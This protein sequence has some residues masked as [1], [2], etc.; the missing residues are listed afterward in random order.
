[1]VRAFSIFFLSFFLLHGLAQAQP[2]EFRDCATCPIMVNIPAG[3]FTMGTPAAEEEAEG[4]PMRAR[5]IAAPPTPIRI[6][7]GFAMSKHPVTLAEFT[8]FFQASQ[9]MP[10]NSCYVRVVEAGVMVTFAERR[11]RDWVLPGIEQLPSE[12]VVCVSWNDAQA[13]A[14][15]LSRQTGRTY[16]LASEAEWE[17]A[18]RAGTTG[19]RWWGGGRER[20]C[21]NA[22]VRDH[23]LASA[24]GQFVRD[25]TYFPCSDG[26]P[27]TSPV[28]AFPAN[29]FGLHDMLG[30]VGVWVAD[31]WNPNLTGIPVDGAARTTGNCAQRVAKGGSWNDSPFN[32][33]AGHRNFGGQDVRLSIIGIRVVR[34]N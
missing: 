14:A 27:F 2:S 12:P 16:R 7:R 3:A 9:H 29:A 21:A 18:A 5:G 17:Y 19:P 10:G 4:V 20:A 24:G 13:Y 25:D 15:W 34:E 6:E 23:S 11:G 8:A 26:F 32:L 30:N 1:M 22:N 31:C 33:R 28:G